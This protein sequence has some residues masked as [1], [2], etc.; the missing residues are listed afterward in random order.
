MRVHV[1]KYSCGRGDAHLRS[2]PEYLSRLRALCLDQ[3]V[4]VDVLILGGGVQGLVL[5][6]QLTERG[7]RCVLATPTD[8]GTGQ[9]LHSHGLLNS[10]NGLLTGQTRD[11]VDE[12]LSFAKKHGL[13]VYGD[14]QWYVL[15]PPAALDQQRRGWDAASYP[16]EVVS[17][18]VL[19]P[20]FQRSTLFEGGNETRVVGLTGFNYPKRQLVRLLSESH[21]DEIV[22]ASVVGVQTA[23][24]DDRDRITDVALQLSTTKEKLSIT[25]G[26]VIA[27]TGTGTKRLVR[28]ILGDTPPPLDTV[29]HTPVHMLCVRGPVEVLPTVSFA[30]VQLGVMSVAHLNHEHDHVAGDHSDEVTW[31]VTPAESE[32][33]HE[34]E[35]P[36]QAEA[37]TKP[38]VVARTLRQLQT[39]YPV[40]QEQ[41]DQ[42]R[43]PIR[44]GVFAGYKQN[45]G[46]DPVRPLADRVA[47]TTNLLVALPSV[48]ANAWPN[49]RNLADLVASQLAPSG[50]SPVVPHAGEGVHV[51]VVNDRTR[52]FAW[53]RWREFVDAYPSGQA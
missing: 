27:A 50:P 15:A 21:L 5:L 34:L 43:S 11:A 33:S 23:R 17:P 51:G 47:N 18:N 53:M 39:V 48:I 31:Y 26:V 3:M 28:S 49:A 37:A 10:G 35:P 2:D 19:P 8:L 30:A 12:A 25:P 14:H 46:D 13:Q 44:L 6:D 9:T 52:N 42:P 40:L 41:A 36:D 24:H 20:G 4:D 38:D 29:T 22:R 32:A 7:Y 45:I 16:Y 1:N